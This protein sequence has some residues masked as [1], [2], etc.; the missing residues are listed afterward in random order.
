MVMGVDWAQQGGS[1]SAFLM[2]GA[3]VICSPA[4]AHVWC[5]AEKTQSAGAGTAGLLGLLSLSVVSAHG[6]SHSMA[7]GELDF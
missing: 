3:G 4:H 2:T 1:R 7:S 5:E 6:L